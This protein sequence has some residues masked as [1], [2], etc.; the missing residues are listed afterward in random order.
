M[1]VRVMPSRKKMSVASDQADPE[2]TSFELCPLE[3]GALDHKWPIL[4]T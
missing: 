4:F 3:R 2:S 1:T